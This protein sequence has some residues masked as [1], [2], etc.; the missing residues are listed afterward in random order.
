MHKKSYFGYLTYILHVANC[1]QN[2]SFTLALRPD[3]LIKLIPTFCGAIGST[4]YPG[5]LVLCL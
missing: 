1:F 3:L 4:S 5:M 2:I